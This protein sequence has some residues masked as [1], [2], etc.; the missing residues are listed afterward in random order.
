MLK[1][2]YRA[3]VIDVYDGDTITVFMNPFPDSKYSKQCEFRV[4]LFG[5]DSEEIKQPKNDPDRVAKKEQA[6]QQRDELRSK[7]LNK[8]IIFVCHKNG[9]GFGRLLGTIYDD[10]ELDCDNDRVLNFVDDFNKSI[11]CY[12]KYNVSHC[13]TKLT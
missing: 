4:R 5:Y 12:M 6:L 11:N 1:G 9:G 7:I 3:K 10:Q 8:Y 13:K 2:V